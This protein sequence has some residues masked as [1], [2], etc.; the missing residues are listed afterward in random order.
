MYTP[1]HTGLVR[2]N[3]RHWVAYGRTGASR[4]RSIQRI[5]RRRNDVCGDCRR[6]TECCTPSTRRCST[7][8]KGRRWNSASPA[9]TTKKTHSTRVASNSAARK[10]ICGAHL[11]WIGRSDDA[12]RNQIPSE[13]VYL[14]PVHRRQPFESRTVKKV[15][16]TL[17]SPRLLEVPP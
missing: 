1:S 15:R 17:E 13:T 12:S 8:C 10:G 6:S 4:S 11:R 3:R 14:V 2:P 16:V 7:Q 9:N 5:G